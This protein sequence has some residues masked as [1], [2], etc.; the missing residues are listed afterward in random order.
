MERAGEGRD[1]SQLGEL[2]KTSH[3]VMLSWPINDE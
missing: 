1:S 3:K 2:G